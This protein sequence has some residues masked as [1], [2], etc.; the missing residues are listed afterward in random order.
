MSGCCGTRFSGKLW[1]DALG[2][3]LCVSS[4][5]GKIKTDSRQFR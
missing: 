1:N 5:Y 4:F 2:D 3:T